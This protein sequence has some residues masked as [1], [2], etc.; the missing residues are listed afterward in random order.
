MKKKI[1]N[2]IFI[3]A[4]SVSLASFILIMGILY[5]YFTDVSKKELKNQT[6]FVAQG[7]ESEG[8]NYFKDL[9]PG[10]T[11]ITWVDSDGKILYDTNMDSAKMENHMERKEIKEAFKNGTGYSVRY[12]DTIMKRSLYSAKLLKNGTVIRLSEPQNTVFSLFL[13]MIQP[14]AIIFF[15]ALGA[16]ILF[17]YR[18]S[19]QIAAPFKT[20]DLDKPLENNAYEELDPLLRKISYQQAE[21]SERE[22]KL[23]KSKQEYITVLDG[24]NEGVLVMGPSG[25]I[26]SIN[27]KASELLGL[28]GDVIDKNI[29]YVTDEEDINTVVLDALNGKSTEIVTPFGNKYYEISGSPVIDEGV[30]IGAAVLF[31]DVTDKER[32]EQLRREFTANVSHE[33]K[34]PLHTISGYAEMLSKG[35]VRDED[36][37]QFLDKIH[38]ETLRM[39]DLINDIINL[40]HLDEGTE[41]IKWEET[42]LYSETEKVIKNLEKTASDYKIKVD[43]DGES[44]V[45]FTNPLLYSEIA[46]NLMDNAIKYNKP[47]GSVHVSV[48]PSDSNVTLKVQDTGIGIPE[49]DM[50]RIYERFYRVNKSRSRELGGTGLGLS[51]VKHAV[52][53]MDAKIEIESVLDKG[54]CVTVVFPKQ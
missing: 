2:A 33:L 40:S 32:N 52:Q 44:A 23:R 8:L 20:M 3:V 27:H 30:V 45:I 48:I 24:L 34:T 22:E 9:D 10:N 12:S 4:V 25:Q 39:T 36:V 17:A 43:F 51:I 46:Q 7:V 6:V 18:L 50:A 49:E 19:K 37:P 35:M 42:D 38:S 13:G 53:V 11:R 28:K 29:L 1:F 5:E 21:L 26:L 47:G 15:I 31:F 41:D 14:I 16:S 54:T